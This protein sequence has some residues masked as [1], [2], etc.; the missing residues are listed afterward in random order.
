MGRTRGGGEKG[1]AEE[2]NAGR[3]IKLDREEKWRKRG[4][5]SDLK[6]FSGEANDSRAGFTRERGRR[7]QATAPKRKERRWGKKLL[8]VLRLVGEE[9]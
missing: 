3:K 4:N 5:G 2:E 8:S 7:M 9:K 1:L 6:F